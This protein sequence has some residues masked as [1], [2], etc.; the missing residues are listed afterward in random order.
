MRL[1]EQ[2]R[3]SE[4][5]PTA[6]KRNSRYTG[7]PDEGIC[8]STGDNSDADDVNENTCEM[9]ESRR[10]TE[11]E[12]HRPATLTGRPRRLLGTQDQSAVVN[13]RRRCLP[14][15][16]AREANISDIDMSA[17]DVQVVLVR[18]LERSRGEHS[19]ETLCMPSTRDTVGS[20]RRRRLPCTPGSS[21]DVTDSD[22]SV[23]CPSE[24][25]T[26]RSCT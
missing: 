19:T 5:L 10:H 11:S 21:T 26:G 24:H 12:R 7:S 17:D 8:A 20:V 25:P 16:P 13:T 2:T 9:A 23:G 6:H 15:V 22:S 3:Q 18:A 14:C 1:E 4:T